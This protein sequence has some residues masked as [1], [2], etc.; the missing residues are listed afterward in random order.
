MDWITT[1]NVVL[2]TWGRLLELSNTDAA[3]HRIS[4]IHGAAPNKS[5]TKNHTKQAQ[6]IRACLLQA[7]EYFEAADA[8]SL[9]TSPNHAYYG[10][11]SLASSIMLMQ[12]DGRKSLD[13]V[14]LDPSN[15]SHGLK[16]TTDVKGS[17]AS[18]R[19]RILQDSRVEV[20]MDGHFKQWYV[21]L[22]R[23]HRTYGKKTVINANNS[24]RVDF[25]PIG[26][27]ESPPFESLIGSKK[28]LLNLF[29]YLPDLNG[30]L[31]QYGFAPASSRWNIEQNVRHDASTVTQWLIHS[32]QS[33][34]A[35]ENVLSQFAAPERSIG[36]FQVEMD[37]GATGA[38]V[39]YRQTKDDDIFFRFPSS[40][41]AL[42]FDHYCY[43]E[44]TDIHEF[45]DLYLAAFGLSMLSRYFPDIWLGVLE[46]NCLAA[47][48]I[49]RFSRVVNRKAPMLALSLLQGR[50]IFISSSRIPWSI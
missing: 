5:V 45:A 41:L 36:G 7:K 43:A 31:R 8:S 47:R 4:S 12:G 14:R 26:Y 2:E 28:T 32:A 39:A 25:S 21:E 9:V 27:F 24:T 13:R 11:V 20:L 33:P 16:F 29:Q 15:R 19:L 44:D 10:M 30:E 34:D 38:I 49:E 42:T 46:S 3:L 35:L 50:D 22:P 37:P 1:D 18:D 17:S 6:Q 23:A 40:R 48:L